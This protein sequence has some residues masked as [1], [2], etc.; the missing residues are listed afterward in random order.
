MMPGGGF[1]KKPKIVEQV[2]V[3]FIDEVTTEDVSQALK[4][5]EEQNLI[6]FV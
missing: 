4:L 1:Q 5:V 3:P 6:I 2:V